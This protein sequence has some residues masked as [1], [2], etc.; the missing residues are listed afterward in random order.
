MLSPKP[1][2]DTI[3]EIGLQTSWKKEDEFIKPSTNGISIFE[4]LGESLNIS[5]PKSSLSWL[6]AKINLKPT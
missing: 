4:S 1:R 6:I 5:K 3:I 2:D